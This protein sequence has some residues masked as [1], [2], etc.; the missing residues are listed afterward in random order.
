M[1]QPYV[2][3]DTTPFAAA[4][5]NIE[6]DVASMRANQGADAALQKVLG[7]EFFI[8]GAAIALGGV[9]NTD[10]A[11][12]Q[13]AN[14]ANSGKLILV[15]ALTIYT[16]VAQQITYLED[17][18]IVTP[19]AITPH[20]FLLGSSAAASAVCSY[21]TKGVTGGTTWSNQSRVFD[22]LDLKLPPLILQPGKSL[23]ILGTS[24]SSQTTTCNVYFV[25]EPIA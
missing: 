15:E 21:S 2:P 4:L 17:A 10:R 18:T 11:T 13:I 22:K 16:T 14:P 20:N 5:T 6:N 7:G 3:F 19:T 12:L 9:I 1:T 23:T 24:S 25:E 8:A